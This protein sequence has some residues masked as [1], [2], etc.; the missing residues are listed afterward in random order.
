MPLAGVPACM[1]LRRDL[2]RQGVDVSMVLV[3]AGAVR[4]CPWF[5]GAG[6]LALFVQLK[7]G[8]FQVL[9]HA[10]TQL[11][12]RLIPDMQTKNVRSGSRL[13]LTAKPMAK[14]GWPVAN[15][16]ASDNAG[17]PANRRCLC[18]LLQCRVR[19]RNPVAG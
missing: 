16:E 11:A 2:L 12:A 5:S 1:T 19:A 3:R 18:H 4:D 14:V 7:A 6:Y 10:P 8:L 17:G 13:R 15:G 9:D